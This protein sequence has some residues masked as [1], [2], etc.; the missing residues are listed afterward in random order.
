MK[1]ITNDKLVRR[2]RLF[3]NISLIVSLVVIG[4]GF[5][6][7]VK[8]NSLLWGAVTMS[9]SFILSQIGIFFG[10]RFGVHPQ[11]HEQVS[12]E[13][14]GLDNHFELLHYTTVVPHL[15][16]GPAGV[17]ILIPVTVKG[18]ISYDS[19]KKR[20]RQKGVSLFGKLFMQE[21]LGRP[22]VEAISAVKDIEK[23]FKKVYKGQ[24]APQVNALMFFTNPKAEVSSV[25]SPIPAFPL[26]KLKDFIRQKSKGNTITDEQLTQL[27][28]F[29]PQGENN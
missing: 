3:G 19:S 21:S 10:N 11:L 4:V 13:L 18:K 26:R 16:V 22:D 8:E 7:L 9:L 6:F 29:L 27:L 23:E 25:D 28:A 15:L 5:Y 24:K 2:Y 17:W 1:I 12:Q 20:W 14:K